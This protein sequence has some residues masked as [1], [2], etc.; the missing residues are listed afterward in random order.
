MKTLSA[1]SALDHKPT[2]AAQKGM[3]A[4]PPDARTFSA[5][6]KHAKAKPATGACARSRL[7]DNVAGLIP[8]GGVNV[9]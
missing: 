3:S 5:P 4:L 1:I 6:K 2:Y 9:R 7:R 8:S